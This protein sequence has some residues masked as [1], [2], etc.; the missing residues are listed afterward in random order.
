MLSSAVKLASE[1][2]FKDKSNAALV[3]KKKKKKN[4][5]KKKSGI[6][7]TPETVTKQPFVLPKIAG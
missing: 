1:S 2:S 7:D 5:K 6:E 3:P 4:S